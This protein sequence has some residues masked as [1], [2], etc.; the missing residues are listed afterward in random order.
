MLATI[1]DHNL[2]RCIVQIVKALEFLRNCLFQLICSRSRRILR[3]ATLNRINSSI[4]D[5]F[6]CIK[7][8]FTCTKSY[9]IFA[10]CLYSFAL[11][12]IANVDDGLTAAA[13]F[14][15]SNDIV[16]LLSLIP[17]T[18]LVRS[19]R[20]RTSS[21]RHIISQNV[22]LRQCIIVYNCSIRI[23]L[24]S[25]AFLLTNRNIAPSFFFPLVASVL[26]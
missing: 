14:D 10:L 5:I 1:T 3:K 15:N 25:H 16:I 11:A 4:A 21:P 2:I 6:R 24:L 13:F 8:R 23:I 22:Y 19:C 20:I 9:Y 17:I 12:V 26:P 7:I 18:L